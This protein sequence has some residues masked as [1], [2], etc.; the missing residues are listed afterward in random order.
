RGGVCAFWFDYWARGVRLASEFP[1]I[2]AAAQFLDVF[3]YDV[4]SFTDRRTWNIPLRFQLC[5]GALAEWYR[6]LLYLASIPREQFSEGPSFICWT[7]QSDGRLSVTS[8]RR[9]L[10]TNKFSGHKDFPSDVIWQPAVPSK[11]ACLC[12]KLFFK[13]VATLDNLQKNGFSLANRCVLCSS[14]FETVDHLFLACKFASDIWTLLSSLLSIHGPLS[15]SIMGFIHGWKGMNCLSSF[16]S[17]MDVLM[18]AVLWFIWKERNDQIFKDS[19]SNSVF[20]FRK[21]WFTV[22][23]WLLVDGRFFTLKLSAWRLV[24][25]NG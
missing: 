20:T 15:S 2:A 16:S 14:N 21:I 22:D 7:P 18:H 13:K 9:I 12:W 6:L 10:V 24:F 25:D 8:L 1:R 19:A 4:V 5:G 11:I 3:V 17:A 23:D